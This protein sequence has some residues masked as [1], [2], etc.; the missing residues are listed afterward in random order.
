MSLDANVRRDAEELVGR[1]PVPRSALLPMLHLLQSVE[2]YVTPEGIAMCAEILDLTTAEVAAV[3]SFYTMYSR[4]NTGKHH[5]GVCTNTM[6]G[7]LGGDAIWDALTSDLGAGHDE[8]T[9]DGMFTLE[10]IECQAACTHAPVVTIDWEFIDDA[11]VAMVRDFVE[12][13]KRGEEVH[14]TRGPAIRSL[15]DSERTIAGFDDGLAGAHATDAKMPAGLNA[16]KAAGHMLPES[17]V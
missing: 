7:L 16:A 9:E 5:I 1:Y 10:R 11:T 15:K 14:S 13:L 4:H 8:T 6:C 2:G 12:R 17:Q 3:S